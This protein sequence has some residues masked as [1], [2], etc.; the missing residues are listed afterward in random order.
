MHRTPEQAM[1]DDKQARFRLDRQSDGC[2]TC[3]HRSRNALDPVA[4]FHLEP[5]EGAIVVSNF[6]R[7]KHLVAILNDFMKRDRLHAPKGSRI[8][9]TRKA[10][11]RW[12]V[13]SRTT[14]AENLFTR[15]SQSFF[16]PVIE[17]YNRHPIVRSD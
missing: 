11:S 8:Q 3:I 4:I 16:H 13:P 17:L 10:G 7:S 15:Y 5:I 14:G 2:E 9:K 12:G 6:G 1:V